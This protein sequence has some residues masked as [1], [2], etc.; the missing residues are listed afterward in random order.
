MRLAILCL[1][2][3]PAFAVPITFTFEGTWERVI[4]GFVDGVEIHE[5]D[6][7][8]GSF[9]FERL[10]GKVGDVVAEMSFSIGGLVIEQEWFG[11]QNL[12]GIGVISMFGQTR[13]N[14]CNGGPCGVIV[15]FQE[16]QR[17]NF[18]HITGA[19]SSNVRVGP[20]IFPV[21]EPATIVLVGSMLILLFSL[22]R[23]KVSPTL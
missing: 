11:E 23:T 20:D 22:I 10:S 16:R 14:V 6:P 19:G 1:L 17:G 9:S 15:V 13:E 3:A 18:A 21:P 8:S 4:P 7:F 5:G 2:A 12:H